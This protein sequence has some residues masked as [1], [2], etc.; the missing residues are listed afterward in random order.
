MERAENG[1]FSA[2]LRFSAMFL[3]VLAAG[4]LS[5]CPRER[6]ADHPNSSQSS[7]S[8][9][10]LSVIKRAVVEPD[11]ILRDEPV[12][13]TIDV[14][15]SHT[16]EFNYE[17]QW[18]VN[19]V[20]VHGATN[21][22]FDSQP[23]HRGDVV[24]VEIIGSNEKGERASYRTAGVS[25]VNAPPVVEKVVLEHDLVHRR[26]IAKAE[27]SDADHDDI[28]LM[29][30]WWRNDEILSEGATEFLDVAGV[31]END[32]V[33]VEV[34]PHDN[35]GAG[36]SVKARPLV[37]SNN[38]PTIVSRPNMISNLELY[39]YAVEAKDPEGDAVSFELETG[40]TGM[41]IDRSSGHV[42]WKIPPSVQSSH[43]VKI[44]AA[45]TKGARSWQEFDL[46]VPAPPEKAG[47]PAG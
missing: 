42:T 45:D 20:P 43:H 30:R 2:L 6:P 47:V 41:V 16:A 14:D 31:A 7:G 27:A 40:P 25:V 1:C 38:A 29:Y 19:R 9:S 28:R 37:G 12:E 4:S 39:E 8:L 11:P 10:P 33:T 46:S 21:A 15:E 18:F 34:I 5:G 44:I 26:L 13:V 32:V 24:Y 22:E 36:E 23:L 35:E 3:L 17:Y